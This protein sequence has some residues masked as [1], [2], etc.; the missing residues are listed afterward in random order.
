MTVP[1][2]GDPGQSIYG[3]STGALP[4]GVAVIRL[5]G[6]SVRQALSLL[7]GAVPEARRAV[8]RTIVAADGTRIDRGLVLFFPA[9]ASF[10]GEDCGELHLHGGPA[11]VARALETLGVLPGFRHAEA[12][13]FT[14][15]AFE[16]GRLDLAEVEGLADLIAAQT[17]MQR[18]LAMEQAGGGLSQLYNGWAD[19]LM[20]ARALIEAELDFAD[21][22]DVPGAVS[23]TVWRDVAELRDGLR[24]HLGEARAGAIIRDGFR[25]VLAG[26]P[27][28]G[29]SSLMNALARRP[30]AIVADEAGTT[31]DVLAVDLNLDGYLVQ[32]FDTAGLRQAAGPVEGEGVRRAEKTIA[33]ADLVLFLGDGSADV[34]AADAEAVVAVAAGPVLRV[35]SKVDVVPPDPGEHFDI[36]LSAHTGEGLGRLEAVLSAR[37]RAATGRQSDAVPARLRHRD[38]LSSALA[39]L[40]EAL[41]SASAPLEIRAEAL[42]RAGDR[43]GRITGRIEP[44]DL[45]GVIFGEFCIGK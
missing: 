40:N 20:R 41:A 9:P 37:V 32:L 26:R 10:T 17:E 24:R 33:E 30:V 39:H 13:E 7:S 38:H 1:S 43:L 36:A 27:N 29:K 18:R 3:L 28:V 8:L 2:L 21:E 14:R 19:R 15:R 31:R 6:P 11:V 22:D 35:R 44:D 5:S 25:V 4:S 45:L 16:N 23:A 42:R 12:G 34:A